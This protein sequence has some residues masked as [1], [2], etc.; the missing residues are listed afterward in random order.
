MKHM[1]SHI[2]LNMLQQSLMLR[3]AKSS[4]FFN[5]TGNIYFTP[6]VYSGIYSFI[7]ADGR[8][9]TLKLYACP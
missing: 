5:L 7:Y 1:R 3:F 2:G 9:A 6:N 8:Q 4:L